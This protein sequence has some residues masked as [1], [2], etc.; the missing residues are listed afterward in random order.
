M[1][2]PGG[3]ND[4]NE[5]LE[6]LRREARELAATAKELVE[7]EC[8]DLG[9]RLQAAK[10]AASRTMKQYYGRFEDYA[11]NKPASKALKFLA[12]GFVA[13]W[14]LGKRKRS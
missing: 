2:Y 12:A 7:S 3:S 14:L 8:R 1:N 5:S 11:G 4:N 6:K 9:R 10:E 13:G